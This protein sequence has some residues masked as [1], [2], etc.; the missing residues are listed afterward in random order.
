MLELNAKTTAL[1]VIDLQEGILPFA[2]GPH[3]AHTVV[4]RTAQLAEKIPYPRFPG[5][6]G[7]RRVV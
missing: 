6:N 5:G 7:A 2:G 4:A 1:V 3:T